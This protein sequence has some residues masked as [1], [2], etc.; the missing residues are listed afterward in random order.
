MSNLKKYRLKAG[1]SQLQLANVSGISLN[2]IQSYEQ[3][4]REINKAQG[5]VLHSLPQALNCT[6]E[7][8]MEQK[9]I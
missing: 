9:E 6:I 3:G 5:E 2:T 7:E 8:I 4:K 1:Y